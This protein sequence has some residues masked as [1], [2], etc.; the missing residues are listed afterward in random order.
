MS[1][2]NWFVEKFLI[3]YVKGV[4]DKLP[5]DGLKVA[6]GLVLLVLHELDVVYGGTQY[7]AIILW[8]INFIN[9]LGGSP[10]V[11]QNISIATIIIGAVHKSL[12]LLALEKDTG[13]R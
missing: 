8:L 1:L 3:K 7:G 11:V 2:Q 13:R 4:L 5:A 10:D 6:L 12:K 9:G